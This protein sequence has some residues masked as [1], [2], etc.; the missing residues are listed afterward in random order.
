[1]KLATAGLLAGILML[2]GCHQE[3]AQAHDSWIN[4]NGLTDP[5]TKHWCCNHDDCNAEPVREVIGGYQVQTGEVI[6]FSRILW[7]SPDG[8]WWRCRFLSGVQAGQ[9]RCLIGPPPAM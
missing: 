3:P 7:K 2:A 4:L 6:P 9:T 8:R 5:V 1:M